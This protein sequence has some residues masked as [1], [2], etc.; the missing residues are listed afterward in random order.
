MSKENKNF[1]VYLTKYLGVALIAGSVVHIGTLQNGFTRYLVLMIVGL[2]CMLVGNVVEA[3]QNGE[4]INVRY[5]LLVT[6]LS[7]GTGFL[8]GGVQH[9]IDNPSYAGV[10]LGVGLLGAYITYF[11]KEHTGL[12]L[13]NIVIVA[14]I[15]ILMIFL[16][17]YVLDDA[18]RG[19]NHHA[20]NGVQ[21]IDVH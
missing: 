7:F 10:L 9:Y 2:L 5:L 16:S 12:R 15:S 14:I 11:I 3:I 8:S 1:L 21:I 17:H 13:H 6:G 20:D 4:K 19:E 18:L